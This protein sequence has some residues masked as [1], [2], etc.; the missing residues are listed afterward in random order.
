MLP[1][2]SSGWRVCR[3]VAGPMAVAALLIACGAK[4]GV[5][6]EPA[7]LDG[8]A[9][10][11]A[12]AAAVADAPSVEAQAG[13][14]GL[15]G[16]GGVGMQ[17][18]GGEG[19][20]A[21]AV[22]PLP[23][24]AGAGVGGE[25]GAGVGGEAGAG[26]GGV[27]GGTWTLTSLTLDCPLDDVSVT[28]VPAY[29]V[30]HLVAPGGARVQIHAINRHGDMAVSVERDTVLQP[31]V[32]TSAGVVPIEVPASLGQ[33]L[34]VDVADTG[35]VLLTTH[36][37]SNEPG[38]FVWQDGVV[39]PVSGVQ[40]GAGKAINSRGQLLYGDVSGN[41]V[42][43]ENGTSTPVQTADGTP[44]YPI[45]LNDFG[46]VL[47]LMGDSA[48]VF[49]WQ[50]GAATQLPF[51]D[52]VAFGELGQVWGYFY[53]GLSGSGVL[54]EINVGVYRNGSVVPFDS[55]RVW[56]S[57]DRDREAHLYGADAAGDVVGEIPPLTGTRPVPFVRYAA[58]TTDLLPSATPGSAHFVSEA[59]IIAGEVHPVM[60]DG[61]FG[62]MRPTIWSRQCFGACCR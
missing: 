38:L 44:L 18:V 36:V 33:T 14:T 43:W 60:P 34:V 12:G 42:F 9:N 54:N 48:G 50:H 62:D 31:F 61:S 45:D 51:F 8:P 59:G 15:G 21:S 23:G 57:G 4:V 16:R 20:S 29:H 26:G 37:D 19:G 39:S 2:S 47:T 11:K 22:E 30:A 53:D 58:G 17:S 10:G 49:L 32:V 6:S 41:A 56:P 13:S 28:E 55:G 3:D 25:A 40:I 46:Q 5:P 35:A 1:S 27:K 52:G 24:E 7:P